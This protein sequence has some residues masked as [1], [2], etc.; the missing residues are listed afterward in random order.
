MRPA[1]IVP[2][3]VAERLT[4]AENAFRDA[5]VRHSV[6][7]LRVALGLVFV[8]FGTLKFFPGLSPAQAIAEQTT[9]ILTFHLVPAG[10]LIELVAVVEVLAGILLVS[11]RYMRAVVALLLF[12]MVGILSPIV[13]LPGE[14]FNGPHHLPSLL[15]QYILKDFVL[16]GAVLVLAAHT[17]GARITPQSDGAT[18]ASV[19][20]SDAGP[21]RILDARRPRTMIAVRRRPLTSAPRRRRLHA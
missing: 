16:V 12:E 2:P 21:P 4:R 10:V 8:L 13:L 5:T 11:G 6:T 20:P 18:E 1:S 14:L 3:G 15:G 7:Y 9:G 19:A 17:R